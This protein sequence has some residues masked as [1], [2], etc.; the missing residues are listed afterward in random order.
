MAS[1]MSEPERVSNLLLVED[2]AG[3]VE[4]IVRAFAKHNPGAHVRVAHNLKAAAE[5]ADEEE[6]DLAIVDFLLPDGRGIDLLSFQTEELRYPVVILTAHG[7][8]REAVE[9]LK[10]GALN[11]VVKSESTFQESHRGFHSGNHDLEGVES[12]LCQPGIC[13]HPGIR[14]GRGNPFAG[15]YPADLRTVRAR[16]AV[17][18][19]SG[20]LI[21][22]CGPYSLRV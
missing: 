4:L 15:L 17:G 5:M 9:A 18:V 13:R 14:I 21:G 16:P 22:R 12:A 11:Y 2:D 20:A 1:E 6:P 8:E 3:H 7:D 19:P 10:A